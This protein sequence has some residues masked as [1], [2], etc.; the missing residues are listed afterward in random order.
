MYW[1]GCT[2]PDPVSSRVNGTGVALA[3]APHPEQPVRVSAEASSPR[4]G[5][6][7]SFEEGRPLLPGLVAWGQLG[8]GRH[9]ESWLAWSLR[10]CVPVVVKLPRPSRLDDRLT[11][12]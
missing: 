6:D 11:L 9:F 1:V 5:D 7:W 8:C 2:A 12:D 4:G 10:H 3:S